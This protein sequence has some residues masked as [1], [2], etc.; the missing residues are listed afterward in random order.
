MESVLYDAACHR[1]SPATMPGF[2]QGRSPR[3]KGLRYQ[4]T[5][6]AVVFP[7]GAGS[8]WLGIGTCGWRRW[9]R[10]SRLEPGAFEMLVA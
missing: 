9:P 2:H 4:P 10:F 8:P 7:S 1:R 5:R 6:L 3:N